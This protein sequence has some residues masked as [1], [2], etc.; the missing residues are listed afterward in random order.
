MTDYSL[1]AE[2]RKS[3]PRGGDV[4]MT[5][6]RGEKSN[7]YFIIAYN[8]FLTFVIGIISFLPICWTSK[9][10][11]LIIS[12]VVIFFVCFR[13]NVA[14]NLIVKFF[15]SLESHEEKDHHIFSK[16]S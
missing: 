5:V 13:V 6:K 16:K 11:S 9:I 2:P 1:K 3:T 14:R 4:E 7:G 8:V 15:S 12:A 10:I